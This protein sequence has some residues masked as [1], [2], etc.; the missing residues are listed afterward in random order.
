M[1][2]FFSEGNQPRVNDTHWRAL[3]K[4]LGATLTGGGG[5]GGTPGVTPGVGLPPTDGSVT[6][7]FYKDT[8]TSVI[9]INT[10]TVSVPTWDSI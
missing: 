7:L 8:D 5:G 4:I 9:Y 3:E 10:G 1:P 6:T 2:D